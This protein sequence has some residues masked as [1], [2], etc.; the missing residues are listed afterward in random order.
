MYV[1]A[2]RRSKK[3]GIEHLL[4]FKPGETQAIAS[5]GPGFHE[6][7][8]AS[9]LSAGVHME[10]PAGLLAPGDLTD[11]GA[12]CHWFAAT[13]IA[14]QKSG[15]HDVS[16]FHVI[17]SA[18]QDSCRAWY[19]FEHSEV[20]RRAARLAFWSIARLIPGLRFEEDL[21]DPGDDM[22]AMVEAFIEFAGSCVLPRDTQAIINA[23]ERLDIPC[24]KLDRDP[25]EGVSGD[26]RIRRHGMLKLGHSRY[27]HIVD[28]TVCVDRSD[29]NS[30]LLSDRDTIYTRL[31]QLNMPVAQQ[32][33]MFRNCTTAGRAARSAQRIGYPVAI[34]PNLRSR[35][36]GITL[37]VT[38][39]HVLAAAVRN[40]QVF[41]RRVIVEKFITGTTWKLL[42]AGGELVGVINTTSGENL[43]VT[44]NP[45]LPELCRTTANTLGFGMIVFTVVSTDISRPLSETGGAIVDLDVA[46]ELDSFLP[47]GSALL[48]LAAERFVRWI[49]PEQSTSRVP[50][51][52]IGGTNG[53]TTT[54]RMIARI[55]HSAGFHTGVASTDG[56]FINDA[57]TEK[58]DLAG[59]PGHCRVLES[60]EVD[61]AVL[62]TAMGSLAHTG[63]IFDWCDVAVCI[64]VTPDHLGNLGINTLKQLADLKRTAL[65][66]SRHVVVINAD[67]P[68]CLGMVPGLEAKTICLVSME[69]SHSELEALGIG[70]GCF[71]VIENAGG[72]QHIVLYR[73]ETR[74]DVCAV[75]DI[76]ATFQGQAAFNISNAQHAIAASWLGG[77][78]IEAIH[79][80]M[81][82]FVMG[83]EE[84]PGRLNVYDGLPFRVVMDYA[85]N[86]D[87]MRRIGEFAGATN[88]EGRKTIL[89]AA[90]GDRKDEEI[91]ELA[92]S[93]AKYFD[94]FYVRA[95]SRPRG[96]ELGEV[97][98]MLSQGLREAG[99]PED[100]VIELP[101][102][103]LAVDH[104][105]R[106]ARAGDLVIL[107]EGKTKFAETWQKIQQFT[108]DTS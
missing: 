28:G 99:V 50:I 49:Y 73:D 68:L 62:E 1:G 20:G 104:V 72:E 27:Q 2:N 23:C 71:C 79:N 46:P 5:C 12:F 95:Y 96:R 3:T 83:Y 22:T 97:A 16:D 74:V 84:T 34:K 37:E 63:L 38:D 94:L 57:L 31:S 100:R 48:D 35:G 36:G 19:E 17:P 78:D 105:L 91:Y 11:A 64:N 65:Q 29:P 108:P 70:K 44:A 9:L 56:V 43:V 59:V 52:S 24:V 15:G 98:R 21:A 53:K 32:D 77:A 90:P 33:P 106:H 25:Y 58:E 30:P 107:T 54:T 89:F 86:P 69:H 51:F 61:C 93:A 92:R 67:D 55:M 26:F 88:P 14:L 102:P 85:H 39:A 18:R 76:P 81:G 7:L 6:A 40:A 101:E 4:E 41:S 13:T 82:S 66:R 80:A 8:A 42:V 10:N 87:G 103:E 75:N 47:A 60:S 45:E